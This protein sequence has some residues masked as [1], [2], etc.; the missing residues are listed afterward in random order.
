VLFLDDLQWAGRTLVDVVLSEAPIEGLLIVGAYREGDVHE[1]HLPAAPLSRWRDQAGVERL[2]LDNLSVSSLVAL[3]AELLHQVDPATAADLAGVIH[4]YTRG[5]PYET[6]ELLSA[7]QRDRLLTAVGTGWRWD[8][9]AVR[10]HLGQSDVAELFAAQV[11]SMPLP[12]RKMVEAIACLGGRADLVLLETA[13]GEPARMVDQALT[14]ALGEGLLVLEPG[15]HDAMRFR[16]DRIREAVLAGLDP[17][18]R[19]GLRLRLA[20]RLAGVPRFSAVAA[21]QYLPV[22]DAIDDAGERARAVGLLRRAAEAAGLIGNHARVNAML[23]AA[24]RLIDPAETAVLVAVHTDRHAALYGLGRLEEVDEEFRAVEALS[25]AA[26]QR[27]VP[28]AVQVASLIHRKRFA[29]ALGLG[30]ESLRQLGINVPVRERLALEVEHGWNRVYRWLDDTD[31]EEDLAR[32]D[33]TDPRLLAAGRGRAAYAQSI[34][35]WPNALI[36]FVQTYGDPNLVMVVLG[37]HQPRGIVSGE[38]PNHNVPISIIADD[39]AVLK[40]IA[41]WGWNPGLRPRPQAP[42]RPMSAF[43]DRF[44]TAFGPR[45]A[46]SSSP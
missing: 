22:V 15:L 9:R 27:A 8:A 39:P 44:L 24:L 36:S 2:R 40:R 34:E 45:P 30:M 16:H 46:A 21:E 20:R 41:G 10:A 33:L 7:L 23:A 35:F 31:P 32:P 19:R 12:T 43:R 5:N 17:R 1:A 42:A 38:T 28:A 11:A 3:V 13:T 29:E 25:A 18:R 4:P 6:V 26:I 14:P 37:D